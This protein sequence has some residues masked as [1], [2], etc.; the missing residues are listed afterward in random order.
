MKRLAQ[1]N[2]VSKAT[3]PAS[4]LREDAAFRASAVAAAN[5]TEAVSQAFKFNVLFVARLRLTFFLSYRRL[6]LGERL[7]LVLLTTCG[8]RG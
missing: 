3:L 1:E 5:T 8:L 7:T 2:R 6:L 4:V